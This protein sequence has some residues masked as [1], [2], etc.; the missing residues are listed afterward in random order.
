VRS[1]PLLRRVATAVTIG[2]VT[3][4]AGS[5]LVMAVPALRQ[6][7]SQSP[8]TSAAYKVGERIDLPPTIHESS[9]WTVLL[10]TRA[11]CGACQTAKP[12][13]ASMIDGLRDKS[14]VRALMVVREGSEAEERDY[15][16]AIGLGDDR[17]IG[18]DFRNLR[19]RRVPTMLLVDRRGEVRY[20]VEG[21]PTL[22]DQAEM[23]RLTRSLD[24]LR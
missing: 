4:V 10:F 11:G 12:A 19:L 21:A 3:V 5:A 20:S 1:D 8:S 18:V 13:F 22:L 15:L 9:P 23:I 6:R 17:L 2:C 24:V 16:R 14:S 7:W